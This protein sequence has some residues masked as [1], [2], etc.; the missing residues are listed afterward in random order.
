MLVVARIPAMRFPVLLASIVLAAAAGAE[1]AAST[2]PYVTLYQVL[3][4]VR[5]IGKYDRLVA[6]ERIE[7]KMP[8]VKPEDI[9]V[10]IHAKSGAIPVPIAAD[11]VVKF[12]ATDAL[13]E[14]NPPVETNQPKGSLA[15]IVNVAL[16]SADGLR[17][18]WSDIENGLEQVKAFYAESR[19]ATA[20]G[21]SGIEV[22]FSPGTPAMLTIEGKTERLLM[23][24]PTGRL[25]VTRDM[26]PESEKP[27]LAFSRAPEF[28]LPYADEKK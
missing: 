16:R 20:P 6:I 19:G 4:P 2:T 9:R 15:F 23:A 3:S 5:T 18:P 13:R 11:G 17:V 26:A 1:E 27:V 22:H 7:S 12:P 14:E 10:V 28:V 8:D 25:I 24:D 21:I